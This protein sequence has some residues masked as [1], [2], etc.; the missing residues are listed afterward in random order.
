[1][2]GGSMNRSQR[3]AFLAILGLVIVAVVGIMGWVAR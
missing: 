3:L 1:M 2:A